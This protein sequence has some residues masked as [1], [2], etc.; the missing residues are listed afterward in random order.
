MLRRR[1]RRLEP[2]N[3]G[4]CCFSDGVEVDVFVND[5]RRHL[6]IVKKFCVHPDAYP[7]HPQ[8]VIRRLSFSALVSCPMWC[9]IRGA[10]TAIA[11]PRD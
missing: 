6:T 2:D 8:P 10:L 1:A 9:P 7:D 3:C 11:G 4:E 5:L